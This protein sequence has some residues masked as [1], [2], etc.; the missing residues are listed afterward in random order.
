M[1]LTSN[2]SA[3]LCV[4]L[5]VSACA[6]V[7]ADGPEAVNDPL[8]GLNRAT[9]GLNK[10]IDRVALRP[11]S[12]AYG[13]IVPNGLQVGIA[14]VTSNLGLPA[15]VLN[16][17][18]QGDAEAAARLSTRFLLNSTIGIAGLGDPATELGVDAEPTDFGETLYVWGV[19]EGVYHELPLLGPSTS[20]DA[21][22]RVVEIFIDPVQ[23][24][25]N[26]AERDLLFGTTA[27]GLLDQRHKLSGVIEPVYDSS[28]DSYAAARIAYLQN[29]RRGL[30]GAADASDLEDPFAFDE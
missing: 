13:T 14:N 28:E 2:I 24:L 5:L 17:A 6:S 12:R 29:R 15:D 3:K 22:G 18:L 20:R 1:K 16:H 4:I 7:E 19:G 26:E 8:E 21:V 10:G 27:L 30:K 23:I 25:A 11:A 9:H